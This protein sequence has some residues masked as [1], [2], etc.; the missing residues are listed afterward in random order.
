MI[1][2]AALNKEAVNNPNK[3]EL[4]LVLF[5]AHYL[6]FLKRYIL[7]RGKNEESVNLFNYSNEH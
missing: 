5:G 4:R 1:V 3:R 6:L 2:L 7:G